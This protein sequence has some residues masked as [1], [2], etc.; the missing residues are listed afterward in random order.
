MKALQ[1]NT[2]GPV[3]QLM[4]V[5]M[6]DPVAGE[7]EI[8]VE[9]RAIGVNFPDALI[10]QGKYQTK[11]AVPFAPGFECAGVV[12]A[13]GA[14]VT[15]FRPGDRVVALPDIGAYAELVR[16]PAWRAFLLP[17]TID[18]ATAAAFLLTYGTA[19]YGLVSCGH[20]AKDETLLVLGASGGVGLAAVHIGKLLG[21]RV[22]AAASSDEKLALCTRNGADDTINYSRDDI[23]TRVREVT[24]G[25]GANVI[26]D[27]VGGD[28]S[29]AALR[30]IAW[31]GRLLVVGFANGVIPRLPANF[32]LL[33]NCSVIGVLWGEYSVREPESFRA[34]ME[35]LLQR[36]ATGELMPHISA[37]YPLAQ[38]V[39]AL[40]AM[41]ERRVTGKVVIEP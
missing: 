2:F 17:D 24:G 23:K 7:G 15:G 13:V 31:R 37:R 3:E 1:C 32:I 41:L 18:F 16:V 14:S 12:K 11:P 19:W 6:P 30:S 39:A 26:L 25:K 38:G 8:L 10:V 5:D 36:F 33:K 27:P 4:L 35:A 21:A 28:F 22:I 20:L 40:Q 29:E 34:E 9:V